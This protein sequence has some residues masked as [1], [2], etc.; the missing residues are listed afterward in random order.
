MEN[1]TNQTYTP[2]ATQAYAQ[3]ANPVYAQ[4]SIVPLKANFEL[5][6]FIVFNLLTC[7]IYGIVFFTSLGEKLNT[8]CG[9][10]NGKATM[11]YCLLFFL[12]SPITC[13]IASIVWFHKMS[14]RIGAELARR[15]IANYNFSASTFWLWNVLGSLIIVG[16]FIYVYKLCQA[17][18]AII[19]DYN[20]RG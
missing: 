19:E 13:G 20:V 18:N 10:K 15:N 11:N 12:I 14:N 16:P 5:W 4:P 2:N 8:A 6:K 3:A 7:G 1:N 17:M 9:N